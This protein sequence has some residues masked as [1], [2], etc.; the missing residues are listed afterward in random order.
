MTSEN[1]S[2]AAAQLEALLPT[3]AFYAIDEEMTG[4]VSCGVASPHAPRAERQPGSSC[5][6]GCV[7]LSL[8]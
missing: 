3:C 1:F 2:E 5:P 4:A 6:H 8:P 7:L